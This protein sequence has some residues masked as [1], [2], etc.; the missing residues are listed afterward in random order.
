MLI[1]PVNQIITQSS[2]SLS[3]Y[4]APLTLQVHAESEKVRRIRKDDGACAI[5]RLQ[6]M[7]GFLHK[8]EPFWISGL[9]IYSGY[10]RMIKGFLLRIMQR[11]F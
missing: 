2:P 5:E 11:P 9:S 10:L 7:Q 3:T 6:A 8:G 4:E 1:I